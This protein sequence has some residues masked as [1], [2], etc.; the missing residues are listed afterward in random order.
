[1]L[2]QTNKQTNIWTYEHERTHNTVGI[3]LSRNDLSKCSSFL[4][5]WESAVVRAFVLLNSYLRVRVCMEKVLQY[6]YTV[7]TDTNEWKHASHPLKIFLFRIRCVLLC[8]NKSISWAVCI[9]YHLYSFCISP[10]V[11]KSENAEN[12]EFTNSQIGAE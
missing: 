7:D 1:M 8:I 6:I 5:K 2:T 11:R 12:K 10:V 4:H 3:V 9:L